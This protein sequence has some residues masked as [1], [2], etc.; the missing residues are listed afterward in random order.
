MRKGVKERRFLIREKVDGVSATG[1]ISVGGGI[2]KDAF[3]EAR[4]SEF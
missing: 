4:S 2:C 3:V 1:N